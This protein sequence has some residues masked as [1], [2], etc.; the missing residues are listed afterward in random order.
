MAERDTVRA[1]VE[2]IGVSSAKLRLAPSG[3]TTAP[4]KPAIINWTS[5]LGVMAADFK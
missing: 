2:P 1:M 5:A 3:A 4:N